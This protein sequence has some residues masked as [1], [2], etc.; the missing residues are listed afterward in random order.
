LNIEEYIEERRYEYLPVFRQE[1][2]LCVEHLQKRTEKWYSLIKTDN[3]DDFIVKGCMDGVSTRLFVYIGGNI[4]C[5]NFTLLKVSDIVEHT[6]LH[7]S[8][9]YQGLKDLQKNML[10]IVYPD[11][12]GRKG[13]LIQINPFYY[14]KGDYS[15]LKGLRE[16]WYS[17]FDMRTGELK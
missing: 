16:V 5:N 8:R 4:I 3:V 6:G 11:V 15:V 1:D 2:I 13:K 12:K 14:F 9:V 7:R 10:I 17:K